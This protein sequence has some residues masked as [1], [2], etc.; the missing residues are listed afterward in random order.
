M[1]KKILIGVGVVAVAGVAYVRFSPTDFATFH[2]APVATEA[3]DTPGINSFKAARQITTPAAEI[4]QAVDL[5]AL[6]TERTLRV[7][8][9]VG[10]GVVTYQT[11]S[12]LM[13]YPDY[14]T[15]TVMDGVE[16][17]L[18]VI[19]AQSRFGAGDMGV[20]RAR[21]EDWLA[22]LGSLVVPTT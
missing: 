16:G 8:G 6:D 14:T 13:G 18:L 21:V 17:P 1:L 2:M 5:I 7:A 19:N 9:S 10:E 20:N 15:V 3:G 22:R 12:A 4:L 11:R